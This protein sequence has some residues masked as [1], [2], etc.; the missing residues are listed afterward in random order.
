MVQMKWRLYNYGNIDAGSVEG[1]TVSYS[2]EDFT[3]AVSFEEAAGA[4]LVLQIL[5][6]RFLFP[7]LVLRMLLSEL[8][9]LPTTLRLLLQNEMYSVLMLLTLL[10]KL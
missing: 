1:L 7:T 10:V 5:T 9:T 6:L 8:V 4:N 2:A 3:V